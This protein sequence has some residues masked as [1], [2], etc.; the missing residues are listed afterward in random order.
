MILYFRM[1]KIL[2]M[3]PAKMYIKVTCTGKV[4]RNGRFY[5][6]SVVTFCI[7]DSFF[8]VYYVYDKQS[9]KYQLSNHCFVFSSSPNS[10]APV[11]QRLDN[12]IHRINRYPVD[13]C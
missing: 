5:E 9:I 13:K 4:W 12:A 11:V 7:Y 8:F 1:A 10:L 2:V 6:V 3:F